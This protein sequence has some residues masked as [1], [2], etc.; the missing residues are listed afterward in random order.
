MNTNRG[1]GSLLRRVYPFHSVRPSAHI[2]AT[3]ETREPEVTAE[4]F[5]LGS[6]IRDLAVWN[7]SA[8]G[9]T[10]PDNFDG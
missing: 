5:L 2:L 1:V 8:A 10:V 3:Y 7:K 9:R 4:L 6:E